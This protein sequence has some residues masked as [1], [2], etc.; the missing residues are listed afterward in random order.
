MKKSEE[1]AEEMEELERPLDDI[2]I[3]N[4]KRI[5]GFSEG[6]I[7]LDEV[8]VPL[9][10]KKPRTQKQIDAFVKTNL[11]RQENAKLRKTAKDSLDKQNKELLD[12]KIITKA[13]ALKRKQ[14]KNQKM[15]EL[16]DEE[17]EDKPLPIDKPLPV[18]KA[19]VKKA[20]VKRTVKVKEP[21]P[22]SD[23]PYSDDSDSDDDYRPPKKSLFKFL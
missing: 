15:L 9:K 19:P 16:V 6:K 18:K 4:G 14:I 1:I 5:N 13:I 23:S 8:Q 20:P 10:V 2:S 11:I 3:S 7:P 22:D 21:E 12:E 17:E